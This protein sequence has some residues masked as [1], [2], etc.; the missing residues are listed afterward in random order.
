MSPES[1]IPPA[2]LVDFLQTVF[3]VCLTAVIA[4]YALDRWSRRGR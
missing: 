2:A 1:M 4:F 3:L